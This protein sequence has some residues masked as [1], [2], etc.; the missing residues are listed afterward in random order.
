MMVA[1]IRHRLAARLFL[2][3]AIIVAAVAPFGVGPVGAEPSL[4]LTPFR[5][6]CTTTVTALGTG[7]L[8]G[9]SLTFTAQLDGSTDDRAVIFAQGTVKADGTIAASVDLTRIVPGC[10]DPVA[11]AGQQYRL[12][13]RDTATNSLLAYALFIVTAPEAAPSLTL[14]PP[15][16]PC[17]TQNPIITVNGTGFPAN[18]TVTI[19]VRAAASEAALFPGTIVGADGR[20]ISTVRLIG[21]GPD[22][23][24]NTQFFV[25]AYSGDSS[26]GDPLLQ[27]ATVVYNTGATSTNEVCFAET[28]QCV[29]GGF[30]ARWQSSG[31]L[32]INGY[33]LSGEFK[34][35]LEDGREYTVQYFER[36]RFEYHPGNAPPQDIQLGQF[37]RRILESVSGAPTAPVSP[38]DGDVHFRET[39]HNVA[40]DIFAYWQANGGLNQFGYPLTEEFS[41]QLADG[42][43]YTVQYF[44]RARFERH[45]ENPQP[46]TILLGQFGRQILAETRPQP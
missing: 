33:P 14:D 7:F 42:K 19:G 1:R 15:T 24:T 11:A 32:A 39:G 30:L 10:T 37:G 18:S 5:G 4:D 34:Q 12:S 27:L 16:G 3:I 38:R 9:Q 45:P 13:A 28:N 26:N 40:P 29:T 44:E 43:T 2:L 22:T 21:C 20:F 31:G 25:F 35:Q 36:V 41:Q 23:P 46:Y 17:P 6:P 8:P